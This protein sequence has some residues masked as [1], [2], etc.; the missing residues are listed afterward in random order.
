MFGL[1]GETSYNAAKGAVYALGRSLALENAEHGI[2]VNTVLPH[3]DSVISR[4]RPLI[5]RDVPRLREGREPI[6]G[7][8]APET[9]APLVAY[10]SSEECAVNGSAAWGCP[11]V[12][13]RA[14][15]TRQSGGTSQG[16]SAA[17]FARRLRWSRLGLA[18]R[19]T[20]LYSTATPAEQA[21]APS[22][23]SST[24]GSSEGAS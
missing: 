10:L 23:A 3:A 17:P 16:S 18:H 20:M 11:G 5:G 4:E 13:G 15:R 12:D 19:Q 1:Q 6:A 22:A 14:R 9:V 21:L 24:I 7:R 8:R 2:R